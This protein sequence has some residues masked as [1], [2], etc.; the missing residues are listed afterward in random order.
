[1]QTTTQGLDKVYE[2]VDCPPELG[3]TLINSIVKCPKVDHFLLEDDLSDKVLRFTAIID[4]CSKNEKLNP[5]ENCE[6]D[7]TVIKSLSEIRVSVM[8]YMAYFDPV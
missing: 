8:T 3:V 6:L 4:Y 5:E 1:V 2:A 7:E